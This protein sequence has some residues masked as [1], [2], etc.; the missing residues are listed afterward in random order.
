MER[1]KELF[2]YGINNRNN[3]NIFSIVQFSTKYNDS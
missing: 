1:D 2:Y 3:N